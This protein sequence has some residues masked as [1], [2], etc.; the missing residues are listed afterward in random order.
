[1]VIVKTVGFLGL[2]QSELFRLND[3]LRRGPRR[4]VTSFLSLSHVRATAVG[5][6]LGNLSHVTRSTYLPLLMEFL[7]TLLTSLLSCKPQ[8]RL[9]AGQAKQ[10]ADVLFHDIFSGNDFF[11]PKIGHK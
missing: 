8:Q 2:D 3:K 6:T 1:M 7:D 9:T 10:R 4:E 5:T 11:R